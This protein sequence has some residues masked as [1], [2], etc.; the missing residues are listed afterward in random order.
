M[1]EFFG[2]SLAI[3]NF[4]IVENLTD[5]ELDDLVSKSES[6]AEVLDG[7]KEYTTTSFDM[8]GF[9]HDNCHHP[10]PIP[11]IATEQSKPY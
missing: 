1:G 2:F 7:L 6:E 11:N 4:G 5:G 10:N 3:L 9:E 8:S